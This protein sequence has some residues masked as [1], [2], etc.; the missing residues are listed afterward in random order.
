MRP[1]RNFVDLLPGIAL[2][3]GVT[4]AAEGLQA[5]EQHIAGRPYLEAIVLAILLGAAVRFFWV[6]GAAWTRGID[7]SAKTLLEIAV[8]LLGASISAQAIATSGLGLLLGV[9]G[10]VAVSLVASYFV[11]RAFRLPH[12]LALLVACG[13]SICGNSAIAAVA[14]VIDA[15]AGEITSSIAF[16]AILG[17]VVVLVL[18][19]LMPVLEL[20]PKQY[21]VLAGLTVYAVPQVLAATFPVGLLSTQMGT[22]VKLMR[23]LMLGPVVLLISLGT[24]R[25]RSKIAPRIKA[26]LLSWP[27]GRFLPWFIIGFVILAS[28]R[29]LGWI[30]LAA[31]APTTEAA[32]FLTIVA[33]AALG[34]SVDMRS[35]RHAGGRV[36][37][38]AV[39]AV[40]MLGGISLVLI[41]LLHIA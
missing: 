22:L 3:A 35:L 24:S 38:S 31:L 4:A 39:V 30:P 25:S 32:S 16:T 18:P 27:I 19:L 15:D 2:C 21:G 37:A 13:N 23:V 34:L 41:R 12:R 5:A 20:S 10:V 7:F 26:S 11:G 14:P 9:A 8:T 17:V 29:S 6:P 1:T 40:L 33:M 28:L 36:T